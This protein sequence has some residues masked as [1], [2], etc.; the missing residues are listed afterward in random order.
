TGIADEFL[1]D[2][3]P[4]VVTK[5]RTDGEQKTV[6]TKK[7]KL[8]NMPLT[9]LVDENSASASEILAGALQDNDRATIIGR[10]TF[11]KG[12]VQV[13]QGLVDGSAIRLTI[14]RYYTPTGRCIQ[15][16]YD[17]G[18]DAYESDEMNRYK[19]GELYS[20][21]SI[22]FP[23]SLKY[24]TPAGKTVYGGG[25]I[26][27]DNFIPLDTT[28]SS[29]YIDELYRRDV[30]VMWALNYSYVNGAKLRSMG[31]EKFRSDFTVDQNMLE[32][33]ASLAEKNGVKKDPQDLKRMA[34]VIGRYMKASLARLIW[35]DTGFTII[36][37]D[38]DTAIANAV[39]ELSK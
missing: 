1:S 31:M 6:A 12:L 2:G 19:H 13:Q 5:G 22:H 32:Q 23:D 20:R 34:A 3:K 27:P 14:A 36:V 10:R 38:A 21:D 35:G 33:F 17:K 18:L 4:I 29:H 11:G 15:K 16:P 28:G 9:V 26:M 30:F 8:E 7:G 24:K 25:G 37:N 39:A